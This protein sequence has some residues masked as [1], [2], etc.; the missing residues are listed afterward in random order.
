[1]PYVQLPQQEQFSQSPSP[2]QAT[3]F[4][5]LSNSFINSP[6]FLVTLSR[7]HAA[8]A[9]FYPTFRSFSLRFSLSLALGRVFDD[10]RKMRQ[11][12]ALTHYFYINFPAF[13]LY[14]RN[15]S[16]RGRK[17]GVPLNFTP[18]R[19][20]VSF[21][22]SLSDTKAIKRESRRLWL[23]RLFLSLHVVQR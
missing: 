3:R 12:S 23:F 13:A 9:Y 14:N 20:R 16:P 6:R 17:I 7:I 15:P 5:I 4:A 19:C 18:A 8:T 2:L 11:G 22:Y 1:M 10:R 21:V